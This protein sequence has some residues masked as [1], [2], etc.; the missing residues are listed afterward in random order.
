[1]LHYG[2]QNEVNQKK[3]WTS[4]DAILKAKRF[5]DN[6]NEKLFKYIFGNDE[7]KRLWEHYV[8]KCNKE[9]IKFLTY[10]NEK[11]IAEVFTNIILDEQLYSKTL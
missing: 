2:D 11:Q 6:A 7:G 9:I 5:G 4:I 3:I 10:L 8:L 1:M